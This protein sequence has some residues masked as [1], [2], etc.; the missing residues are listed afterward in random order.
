MSRATAVPQSEDRFV[1]SP[2]PTVACF[3][4]VARSDPG[5]LPRVIEL[6]AKRGLVPSRC[7]AVREGEDGA[8]LAIDLEMAGMD[9]ELV[10]YVARCLQ[11]IYCVDRVLTAAS[12][13]AA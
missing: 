11:Q 1:E 4:I 2:A 5:V 8:T 9:G 10:E 7:H 6:F 12:R 3:S 13:P